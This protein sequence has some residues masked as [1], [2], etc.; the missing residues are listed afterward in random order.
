M[1]WEVRG[2]NRE[3]GEEKVI[4]LDAENEDSARRRAARTGLLVSELRP[5]EGEDAEDLAAAV[6]AAASPQHSVTLPDDAVSEMPAAGQLGYTHARRPAAQIP[7]YQAIVNGAALLNIFGWVAI[8]LGALI[9]IGGVYLAIQ[10]DDPTLGR[11]T[12]AI[13]T[14]LPVVSGLVTGTVL[15]MAGVFLHMQAS[16]ALAVRDIAIN[17]FLQMG[18]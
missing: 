6:L 7:D 1:R 4:Y 9:I 3:N 15:I 16:L 17:S 8:A 14:W 10:V 13:V 5:T 12:P 11:E 18:E 2:A